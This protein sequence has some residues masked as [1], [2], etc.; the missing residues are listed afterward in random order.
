M[1]WV[2]RRRVD[3]GSERLGVYV[4]QPGS[5]RSYTHNIRMARRFVHEEY[6]KDQCCGNEFVVSVDSQLRASE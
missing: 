4:A 1:S 3:E 6:A 2:I 5:T